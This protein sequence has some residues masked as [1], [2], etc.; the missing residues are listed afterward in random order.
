M[1]EQLYY[2]Y[3]ND[4]Y[5]SRKKIIHKN[6]TL[7]TAEV[8]LPPNSKYYVYSIVPMPKPI[9]QPPKQL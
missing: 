3:K 7:K 8:M 1:T 5:S 6:L 4:R 2:I 9:P